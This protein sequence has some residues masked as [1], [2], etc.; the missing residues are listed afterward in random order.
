MASLNDRFGSQAEVQR[1]PR[2]VRRGARQGTHR[3]VIRQGTHRDVIRVRLRHPQLYSNTPINRKDNPMRAGSIMSAVGLNRK[4]SVG[5]GMSGVG[6]KA[7][8]DLG[9]LE[10]C[11]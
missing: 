6:G 2:N 1:E 10:V 8:V 5:H 3:D 4:S 7:E 11:F 9:R